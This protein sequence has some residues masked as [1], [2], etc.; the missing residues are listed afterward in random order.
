MKIAK[1]KR[2]KKNLA[3]QKNSIWNALWLFAFYQLDADKYVGFESYVLKMMEPQD[4][5]E[6]GFLRNL[7]ES[8]LL[9]GTSI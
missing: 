4:K 3:H 5:K 6:P 2:K 8:C 1:E 9:S 7:A